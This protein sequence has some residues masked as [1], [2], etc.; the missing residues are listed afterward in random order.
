VGRPSLSGFRIRLSTPDDVDAYI[1]LRR[2]VAGEGRGI[3]AELPLDEERDRQ[4]FLGSITSETEQSFVAVDD[5]DRL[6]GSLG[7]QLF[8]Y[9]VAALG[10]MVADGWR[11]RG[12]GSA[13][14]EAGLAWARSVGAHKVELQHWPTNT[15]AAALYDK[16][17]FVEE[18]RLRRHYRRRSGELWDAV[19]RGLVLDEETPGGP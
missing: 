3:G 12:V 4:I 16:F 18:G 14:L 2:A 5:A 17:G 15:A 10:M 6:I 13:L 1:A 8:G 19:V 11:G 9:G 7:I